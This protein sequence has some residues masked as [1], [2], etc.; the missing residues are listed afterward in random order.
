MSVV[1][2]YPPLG[3]GRTRQTRPLKRYLRQLIWLC[4]LPLVLLA[5]AL[6]LVQIRSTM[7]ESAQAAE[8]RVRAAAT[9]LDLR[10][11]GRVRM[12]EVLAKSPLLDS[13]QQLPQFRA[14]ALDF[15]SGIGSDVAL[16]AADGRQ[17]L[18]TQ[19]PAGEALPA[20]DVQGDQSQQQLLQRVRTSGK[21]AIGTVAISGQAQTLVGVG[22]PVR[23]PAANGATLLT[24]LDPASFDKLLPA[25]DLP[26]GW[27]LRLV[28]G[29]GR[30]LAL[31]GPAQ[32]ATSEAPVRF[33][34]A[35]AVSTWQVQLD[36]PAAQYQGP[37]RSSIW[38]LSLLLVAVTGIGAFGGSLAAR[39]LTRSVNALADIE[40]TPGAPHSDEITEVAA[41]RTVL[42]NSRLQR[43]LAL[44]A[45][46]DSQRMLQALF[47]G[48]PD[49]IVFADAQRRFSFVNP[50]FTRQFQYT[51]DEVRGR[52]TELIYADPADFTRAGSTHF[53]DQVVSAGVD[54]SRPYEMQYR[55]RD[56]STFWGESVGLPLFNPEGRLLG[57]LGIHRDIT[58]RRLAQQASNRRREQVFAFL[59]QAP[60]SIAMFDREMNF[61]AGSGLWRETH[62][63]ANARIQHANR[64]LPVLPGHWREAHQRALA[65]ETVRRNSDSWQ[66]GDAPP[67]HMNWVM[68][69]WL[70]EHGS[71]AG[72][73]LSVEDIG[74]QVRTAAQLLEVNERFAVIFKDSPLGAVVGR[75]PEGRVVDVNP[76][77]EALTGYS[78]QELL[79]TSGAD[80]DLWVDPE[81]MAFVR[82]SLDSATSVRG[83]QTQFRRKNGE[84]VDVAI[85]ASSVVLDGMAHYFS[86]AQ[87]ITAELRTRRE[88]EA[89]RAQL[90]AMVRE[91]TAALAAANANLAER[92]R[93]ITELYDGAPC[94]YLSLSADGVVREINRTALRMLG[95]DRKALIGS[96]F[97]HHLTPASRELHRA[98]ALA[99]NQEGQARALV[100]DFVRPDGS[101]FAALLDADAERDG[102]GT[103]TG[104][105]ATLVDDSDRRTREAQ[106]ETMQAELARRAEQA[107]SA[108]LAK[109]AFVANMS[110]EIRTPLNAIIGLT[111]LMRPQAQ[112]DLQRD[113]LGKVAHSAQH[114][115]QVVNDVLDLSKIEAGKMA[116]D[117]TEFAL[118]PLLQ[119]VH[120]MV[121]G[122]AQEKGL[123]LAMQA[124]E[125]PEH[126]F[127]DATRL[128]QALVNLLSNAVKFTASGHVTLRVT[129]A[130]KH[131]QKRLLRFEVEDSGE[132]IS[133]ERQARLFQAF[134]QADVS[135]ARRHGG[136]GLGLVL[137]RHLVELMGG[138][139]GLRSAVGQGSTFWFTAWMLALEA[140]ASAAKPFAAAAPVSA[141]E[142]AGLAAVR[143]GT[144]ESQLA[145]RH[146]GKRVL[147]AEDN[148]VNQEVASALLEAV[149]LVVDVVGDGADAVKAVARQRYDLVLMDMQMPGMDGLSATRQIRELGCEQPPILAM[150]ANA[151]GEDR[152]ACLAAGMNDHIAKPVDAESMYRTL[153]HW[154]G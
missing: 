41:V 118:T 10:L 135:M 125:L 54:R 110:H 46:D 53:N 97:S 150:T 93:A 147:L 88:L 139:V 48:I 106:I 103:I 86:L 143:R 105:R 133:P 51:A 77:A 101:V 12:L 55:R 3:S 141:N 134:E 60:H 59:E 114:L 13:A 120:D 9:A 154:L 1:N 94:G 98:R 137:T 145:K 73:I 16:V 92:T 152:E 132:G 43:E 68:V 153:L 91:R 25:G 64:E 69:P 74:E 70:D 72:V 80:L 115:L 40:N 119:S 121:A 5:A 44:A 78:R 83:L 15:R 109:S 34:A 108:N 8:I 89:H 99:F 100:Y 82:H 111:R 61:V 23:R 50:A 85:N 58:E 138:E 30:Q 122:P 71:S 18:N 87:D 148:A 33:T 67:L 123:A 140:P 127:G 7:A 27:T 63:G 107:E 65:G 113:R 20:L 131:G 35:S 90:E 144:F 136:T 76:A 62:A 19:Q 142:A 45:R 146:H 4:M 126:W 130:D 28:D 29:G 112:D 66:R 38:K 75:L 56:G 37:L 31:R 22:V 79:G 104:V 128:T 52:S 96:S 2:A 84:V 116:L 47:D 11:N 117:D 24:L 42:E 81:A 6:G 57:M 32:G 14:L 36:I 21:P 95:Q 17:L 129:Q 49:G 124:S 39:L 149:G 26:A 151:F 102:T